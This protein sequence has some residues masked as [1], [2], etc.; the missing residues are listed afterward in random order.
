MGNPNIYYKRALQCFS[1]ALAYDNDVNL[2]KKLEKE[3]S[4]KTT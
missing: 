3:T 4:E 2:A 1:H